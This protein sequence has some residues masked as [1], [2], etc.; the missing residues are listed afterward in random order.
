MKKITT[1]ALSLAITVCGTT[2]FAQG[3]GHGR[4]TRTGIE[5]AEATANS[6]GDRGIENA[7]SK[8]AAHRGKHTNHGKHKSKGHKK[9]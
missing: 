9:H 3:H 2:G 8:Q 6:H 5:R 1:L 4:S 7:E